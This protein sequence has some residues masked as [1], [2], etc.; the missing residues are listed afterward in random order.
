MY[1]YDRR[2]KPRPAALAVGDLLVVVAFVGVGT[3]FH[4]NTDPLHALYVAVPFVLGW[5]V[6]APLAGAYSGFPSLRN[7]AF[8]TLGIWT[9]ASLL[10]LGVRSTDLFA[11]GAALSFG[12]VMVVGGG[13]VFVVWRLVV[14][15][16]A[17]RLVAAV[18]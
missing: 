3:Y 4:G 12:F 18:R 10:G 15:R 14:S 13:F 7:E 9:V 6:V 5:F 16:A 17:F 1:P 2:K 8:A 11:G